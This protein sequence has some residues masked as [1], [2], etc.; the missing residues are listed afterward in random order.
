MIKP[1]TLNLDACHVVWLHSQAEELVPTRAGTAAYI[2]D[3]QCGSWLGDLAERSDKRTLS[4]QSLKENTSISS[5]IVSISPCIGGV[6]IPLLDFPQ[7][8]AH[9]FIP[10]PSELQGGATLCEADHFSM[11]YFS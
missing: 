6:P 5:Q 3:L 1:L 8:V 7:G 4:G 10:L 11:A 9:Q 2:Q